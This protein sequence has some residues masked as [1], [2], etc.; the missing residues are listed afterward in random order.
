MITVPEA[1]KRAGKDPETI[2]RWIR[3]GR[4]R[5]QKIGTQHVIEEEDLDAFLEDEELPVPP[6][7][8]WDHMP[9]GRPV[10][11]VVR[12]IRLSRLGH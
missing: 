7:W 12:A 11:N 6:S 4:L 3:S 5:A 2:R 8:G 9:D 1:A 10:P